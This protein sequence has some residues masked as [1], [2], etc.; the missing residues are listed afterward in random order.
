MGL[1]DVDHICIRNP[2]PGLRLFR[3]LLAIGR[4]NSREKAQKTQK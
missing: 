2:I 4:R 3:W 1:A